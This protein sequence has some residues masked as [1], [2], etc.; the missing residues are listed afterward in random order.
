MQS[1]GIRKSAATYLF[2]L[3]PP[4][5][6]HTLCISLS[7]LIVSTILIFSRMPV[8]AIL[9]EWQLWAFQKP[10]CVQKIYRKSTILRNSQK[11]KIISGI[12]TFWALPIFWNFTYALRQE[13]DIFEL[14]K[15]HKVTNLRSFTL[16]IYLFHS[17]NELFSEHA[18]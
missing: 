7:D 10:W 1:E 11:E 17:Q 3:S 6:S 16:Y 15:N 13:S 12:T 18:F 2:S 14:F 4:S 8:D 5:L 9:K